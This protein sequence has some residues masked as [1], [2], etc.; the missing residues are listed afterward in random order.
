[1]SKL[2][3]RGSFIIW[4]TLAFAL[5]GT[6]IGFALDFGHAYLEKARV[7]RLIDA[8]AIAAAK[9]LKGQAGLENDATRAACDSMTMNGALVV[10]N[11]NAC[12]AIQ[13][14][15]MTAT[16]SFI[17]LDVPGGSPVRAVRIN[18]N[19]PVPT[20]FLRFLG[21]MAPGNYSTINVN[22]VAEAGPERPVDLMLVLDRSGS[23]TATSGSGQS[24]INDLKTAVNGFLG[25][26]N[27]FSANDRIGMVSFAYR[28]CGNSSGND[29]T[30]T[31]CAPD[32]ALNFATSNY[33]NTLQNKVNALVATGGTNTME[34]L[35]TARAALAP[36]FDDASRALAR[37]AVLFVTDGQPTY[38]R[39]D[40][41][42]ACQNNPRTGSALPSP[43]NTGGP[44]GGCV[45]G[46]ATWTSSNSRPYIRRRNLG[47]T[48]VT[49]IP[50]S[51]N[52]APLFRD[53]IRCTRSWANCVTNG[54]MYEANQMRNCGRNNS[55]CNDGAAEHDVVFF[56]IAIGRDTSTTDP[57][58][59]LDANA[60]CMLARMANANDI[61]NAATGIVETMNTVC[62]NVFTTTAVDGD[63]HADL[64]EAWP[65]GTGPC[66]DT[67]QQKGKVYTIDVNGDVEAQ[68]QQ[69]FNEIAAILKLRLVL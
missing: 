20:T 64:L 50:S 54:A 68:L 43:G 69:V 44:T 27:T 41:A 46:V 14:A 19:E 30:A 13:G 29:S 62:G 39:L 40:S 48:T 35:R 6:F 36:S 24:K 65:C 47:L 2:N 25:L 59:S 49:D 67:T 28:G 57:Q 45:I 53:L 33:I 18:A 12:T 42:S 1:M 38:M 55:A 21:W 4:F 58:S 7:A 56:A 8:A 3:Q 23:M 5:L 61:L 34:A 10:M 66:I 26:S 32:A 17:N 9:V 15:P 63:T 37:K 22:A 51:L 52:N 31:T 60:K 16:V 11:G